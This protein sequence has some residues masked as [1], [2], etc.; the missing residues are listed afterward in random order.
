MVQKAGDTSRSKTCRRERAGAWLM[1]TRGLEM[2]CVQTLSSSDLSQL[3]N[4]QSQK[5]PSGPVAT[6]TRLISLISRTLAGQRRQLLQLIWEVG[7]WLQCSVWGGRDFSVGSLPVCPST[8]PAVAPPALLFAPADRGPPI[9]HSGEVNRI[10]QVQ[11][12]RGDCLQP[13]RLSR[14]ALVRSCGIVFSCQLVKSRNS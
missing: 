5:A 10:L 14:Q 1:T 8:L 13:P 3:I 2:N 11:R 4:G 12:H 7:H 9:P 6:V